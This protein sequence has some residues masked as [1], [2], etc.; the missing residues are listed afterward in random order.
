MKGRT[1]EGMR[2]DDGCWSC[3]RK[4]VEAGG[5]WAWIWGVTPWNEAS[6]G[7][8][9]EI[10]GPSIGAGMGLGGDFGL[11]CEGALKESK[12]LSWGFCEYRKGLGRGEVEGIFDRL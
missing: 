3:P 1:D 12:G 2:F 9:E 10:Y 11:Y 4:V 6:C 8:V 7:E 5:G